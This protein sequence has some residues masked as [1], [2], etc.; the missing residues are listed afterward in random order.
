ML[1]AC[2]YNFAVAIRLAA[3]LGIQRRNVSNPKLCYVYLL[4]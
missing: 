1:A 4:D 2:A 3:S